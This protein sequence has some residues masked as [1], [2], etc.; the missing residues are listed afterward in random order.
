[1][2]TTITVY[3]GLRSPCICLTSGRWGEDDL[4]RRNLV[5]ALVGIENS[6][7]AEGLSKLLA[8]LPSLRAPVGGNPGTGPAKA[9]H[10]RE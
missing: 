9:R 6:A 4:P 7:S 3:T 5:S 8:A 1:M 2:A 10:S